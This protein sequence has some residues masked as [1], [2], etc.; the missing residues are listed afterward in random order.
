MRKAKRMTSNRTPTTYLMSGLFGVLLGAALA[1]NGDLPEGERTIGPE[2]VELTLPGVLQRPPV[3]FNHDKH[4]AALP[5]EGCKACHLLGPQGKVLPRLWEEDGADPKTQQERFHKLCLRCHTT[6]QK[7]AQKSGPTT[8]GECHVRRL[9]A[10]STRV[11]AAFN[12]ALHDAHVKAT[13]KRCATC[14][15]FYDETQ[16]KMVYRKGVAGGAGDFHAA[17]TEREKLT[18]RLIAHEACINCH[19]ERAA[20]QQKGGPTK[21]N[22][23]HGGTTYKPGLKPPVGE[24]LVSNQPEKS[25]IQAPEAKSKLVSFDHKLHEPL[26]GFCSSCHHKTLKA[27]KE[28]HILV[29]GPEGNGVT[30]EMAYHK[31]T[32]EHSCV[33]CHKQ[34]TDERDC[35]GCH[36]RLVSLPGIRACATCHRGPQPKGDPTTMPASMPA[37]FPADPQLAA[38]PAASDDLPDKVT[39]KD[40]AQKYRPVELPHRKIVARLDAIARNSKLAANFHGSTDV[41]CSGC[42][43]RTPIGAR[44]QPCKAC[45]DKTGHPEQDKPGLTAA[46]HRQCIGCHQQMAIKEVGCTDCHKQASKEVPR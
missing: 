13:E 6:R 32:S 10:L 46:Y 28:C 34:K 12:Y 38:L 23:C 7:S 4:T 21:C 41:L 15:N 2:I 33:G 30:M 24:K 26:V 29:G 18:A 1:C 11:A 14:H 42:H 8:C 37:A 40:L 36:A 22:G 43:H 45:H 5:E 16:K 9:P 31:V 35:A 39:I 3:E 17:T 44:P 25:W 20:A 19:L 27:C